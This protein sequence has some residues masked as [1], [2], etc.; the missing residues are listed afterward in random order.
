M[1]A[2][3]VVFG[4]IASNPWNALRGMLLLLAGVPVY[5]FWRRGAARA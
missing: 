5:L 4:S 3:Y 2:L 1:A